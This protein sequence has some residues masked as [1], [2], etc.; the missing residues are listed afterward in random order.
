MIKWKEPKLESYQIKDTADTYWVGNEDALSGS[1]EKQIDLG[2]CHNSYWEGN[3]LT[4]EEATEN[5]PFWS[6]G[7]GQN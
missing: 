4:I 5:N 7:W 6:G 2:T 1:G 3:G